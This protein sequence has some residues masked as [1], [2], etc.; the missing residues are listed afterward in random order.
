MEGLQNSSFKNQMD[1]LEIYLPKHRYKV[2]MTKKVD[3]LKLHLPFLC[4]T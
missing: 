3:Q 2:E 1:S 4:Y